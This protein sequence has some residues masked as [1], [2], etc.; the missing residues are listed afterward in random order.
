[1]ENE[2]ERAKLAIEAY[3]KAQKAFVETTYEAQFNCLNC[4]YTGHVHIAKGMA[5][6]KFPCPNCGVSARDIE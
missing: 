3:T 1:M 5:R 4:G 6:R 2:S